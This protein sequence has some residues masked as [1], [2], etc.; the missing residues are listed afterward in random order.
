MRSRKRKRDRQT[1]RKGGRERERK[2]K[3]IPESGKENAALMKTIK[4]KDVSNGQLLKMNENK[5]IKIEIRMQE[6]APLC[7]NS[8][9]AIFELKGH[10]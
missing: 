9:G 4:C 6:E 3:D 1:E 8:T 7:S 10:D 5:E 2:V